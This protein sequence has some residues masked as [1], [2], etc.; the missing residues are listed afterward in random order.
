MGLTPMPPTGKSSIYHTLQHVG[1]AQKLLLVHNTFT[2]AADY[3]AAAARCNSISWV[4]CP[5]SNMHIERTLPP[6]P[7]LRAKGADIA[8]GTDSLASNAS[9]NLLDELKLLAAHF[10]DIPLS[11]MLRWATL[12]GAK[13]L[14]VE[15]IFGTFEKGKR[16][17][18]ALLSK[19]DLDKLK[20]T[21]ETES[22][23]LTKKNAYICR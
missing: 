3:D 14:G 17:G 4:L 13:A 16:P 8:L 22:R 21:P 12:G 5:A 7:M 18:V 20:L 6:L 9:L 23:L 19:L 1:E 2:S 15:H 10:P 11:E